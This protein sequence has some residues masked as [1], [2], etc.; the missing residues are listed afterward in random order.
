MNLLT[1]QP[2]AFFYK[3]Y[4]RPEKSS[5][6]ERKGLAHMRFGFVWCL[7]SPINQ[8]VKEIFC[9]HMHSSWEN[10]SIKA[11]SWRRRCREKEHMRSSRQT[12]QTDA[13]SMMSCKHVAL[14][15]CHPETF[16]HGNTGCMH[17][18]SKALFYSLTV[19]Q[20]EAWVSL[21]DSFKDQVQVGIP[22]AGTH[23]EDL[24]WLFCSWSETAHC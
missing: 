9:T 7:C 5:L 23:E 13:W 1:P 19:S 2:F 16:P 12:S 21:R 24:V 8:L 20:G 11:R 22:T 14:Q 3:G 17:T 4:E 18:L 15:Q 6:E 10:S